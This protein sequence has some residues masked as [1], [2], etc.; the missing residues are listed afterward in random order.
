MNRTMNIAIC[1]SGIGGLAAS[2]LLARAGHRITLID[3]FD[4]P[5]PIGSG[6]M[7]QATGLAVLDKLGL[8]TEIEQLSSALTRLWGLSTPSGRTVLDVRFEELR[9]SLTGLG[10]QRPALFGVLH[11][12]AISKNIEVETSR[13]I[14][15]VCADTGRIDFQTGLSR[16]GFDLVIDAMGVR[17]PLTRAPRRELAYGAL[18]TTL[19]WPDDS[20]FKADA[21][22]QRYRGARQMAGVMAS[23]RLTPDSP[24][25]LTYFWSIRGD[26]EDAWRSAPLDDW[27]REAR[28]LWPETGMLLDQITDHDQLTFARYRHRTHPHPV[29]GSRLVHIGDAW[30]AASPQ[31][32]QGANMA[33]LDAYALSLALEHAPDTQSALA[34]YRKLRTGH[35]RLYQ[36]MSWLFT[37]VYQGDGRLAPLIRDYIAAPISRIPP[38]PM[39]LAAMVSGAFGSPLKRLALRS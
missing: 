9:R 16:S 25:S 19:D 8:T 21:L 4:A 3:R 37:P 38:A 20:P 14:R 15:S 17:S 27:K 39:A 32:G 6:L 34:A 36:L 7:L 24:R 33:L 23:G 30:H 13:D 1:G 18:W 28:A 35:V 2:I 12:A 11:Q 22:E 29:S 10:I 31:L 26:S 5:R